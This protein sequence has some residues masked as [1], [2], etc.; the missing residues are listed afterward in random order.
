MWGFVEGECSSVVVFASCTFICIYYLFMNFGLGFHSTQCTGISNIV[1]KV[2][3]PKFM[4]QLDLNT[5]VYS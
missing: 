2:G 1:V 3:I 4:I 5:K